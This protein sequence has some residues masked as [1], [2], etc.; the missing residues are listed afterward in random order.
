M[1]PNTAQVWPLVDAHKD[2]LIKLSD[3]V[4]GTPETLFDEYASVAEHTAELRRQGVFADVDIAI[5][6]HPSSFTGVTDPASLANT[7]IDFDF[8]GRSS[9]AAAAPHLG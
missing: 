3:R 5:S 1:I 2:A 6:W 7:F 8:V 4:W 9:H